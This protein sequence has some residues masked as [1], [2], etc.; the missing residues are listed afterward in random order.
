MIRFAMAETLMEAR[1]LAREAVRAELKSK[2][3]KLG[4]FSFKD[5]VELGDAYLDEHRSEL[6]EA[7]LARLNEYQN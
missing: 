5:L 7:A 2:G 4:Q 6:I 3:L 1:R